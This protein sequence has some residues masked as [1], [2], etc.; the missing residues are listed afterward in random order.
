MTAKKKR[1]RQSAS[2][3]GVKEGRARERATHPNAAAFPA[4]LA[5]PALRALA[6]AG[7]RTMQDLARWSDDDLA[8]LHG[9]GP[10][11]LQLLA[12]AADRRGRTH[13]R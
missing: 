13:H 10:K 9:M 7:I 5:G 8:A 6:G 11:A 3:A 2:T 12:G 1:S 4:G